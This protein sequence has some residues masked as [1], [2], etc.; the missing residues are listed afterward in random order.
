MLAIALGKTGSSV[1]AAAGSVGAGGGWLVV[2]VRELTTYA[3]VEAPTT[4]LAAMATTSAGPLRRPADTT[5]CEGYL[6]LGA[7]I[8][9]ALGP[10]GGIVTDA[11]PPRCLVEL[12][13]GPFGGV[14]ESVIVDARSFE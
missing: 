14:S 4:M 12:E 13:G 6:V 5:V 7:S 9:S 8:V 2:V 1:R 3:M 11:I 10:S